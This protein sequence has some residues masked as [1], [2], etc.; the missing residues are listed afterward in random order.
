MKRNNLLTVLRV[1]CWGLALGLLAG[2]GGTRPLS[3]NVVGTPQLNSA[4]TGNS[5]AAVVRIY[6]LT[7]TANFQSATLESFWRND[8]EALGQELVRRQE[9]LL[10]PD[11]V[12]RIE[13][14]PD[15]ATRY[16][17]VA[18]DLRRPA[19]EGWRQIIPVEQLRNRTF[20]IEIGADR[21]AILNP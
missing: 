18:A 4:E 1:T 19:R 8:T 9:L 17:G 5:N 12:E 7:G 16:I 6:E 21:I 15:P 11:T 13:I 14:E 2:C 20:T 3:L 10:Y